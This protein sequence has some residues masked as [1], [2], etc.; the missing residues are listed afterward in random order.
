MV[1]P[2][3]LPPFNF[4]PGYRFLP[5]DEEL[6]LHY[7]KKRIMNYVLPHNQI[8]E[9]NL[10]KYSPEELSGRYPK[11][12][13][14]DFYFF[15]HRDRKYKNGNRP[16][17]AAGDG[18][19]KAT[20]ADKPITH[21]V[22]G[23][24]IGHKK[25]LVY[26]EG[27]PPKGEKTNWIM[28]EFTVEEGTI[29]PKPRGDN[30]DPMRLD[31]WVLC[32]IHKKAAGKVGK[33][34]QKEDENI[35]IVEANTSPPQDEQS[36]EVQGVQFSLPLNEMFTFHDPFVFGNGPAYND[37]QFINSGFFYPRKHLQPDFRF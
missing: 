26:Y 1:Q 22:D 15:T 27:R 13:E 35:N 32:R 10:Y 7:L 6:I 4:P 17:R 11:L 34:T 16:S 24:V 33:S 8:Q 31:D 37:P 18:Y 3:H 12:G 19:W 30:V 20:T 21:R 36:E 28:H 14:K 5:T 25:T 2:F 23:P 29:T 9:V